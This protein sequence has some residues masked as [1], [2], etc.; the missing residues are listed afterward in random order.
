[1]PAGGRLH[2]LCGGVAGVG[3]VGTMATRCQVGLLWPGLKRCMQT[4]L[5]HAPGTKA[6]ARDMN[7]LAKPAAGLVLSSC[8]ICPWQPMYGMAPVIAHL[9]LKAALWS[10]LHIP[11]TGSCLEHSP[12]PASFLHGHLL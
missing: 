6:D 2:A 3:I 12:S 10:G 8:L 11:F 1:M 5:W 4:W 7:G 9:K